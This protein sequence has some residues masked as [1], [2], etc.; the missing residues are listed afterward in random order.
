MHLCILGL[1]CV[2]KH[3][4]VPVSLVYVCVCLFFYLNLSVS[5]SGNTSQGSYQ[6]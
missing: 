1:M 3:I 4:W 2:N 5:P 6:T